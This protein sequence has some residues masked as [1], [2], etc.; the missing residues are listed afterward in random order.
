MTIKRE[1]GEFLGVDEKEFNIATGLIIEYKNSYLFSIQNSEKWQEKNGIINIGIVGIGGGCEEGETIEECL[2][3]ETYEEIG[4][5]VDI[6][7][8]KETLILVDEEC[9]INTE[10]MHFC[11][12]KPYAITLVK[13][14][15]KYRGKPYTIVFSYRCNL[16]YIPKAGDVYGFVLCNK[17]DVSAIEIE[18]MSYDKWKELGAE[19]I[20]EQS[21]PNNSKLIPF[22]TFRSF[23][24][25]QRIHSILEK[26]ILDVK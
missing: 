8:E 7:D 26:D 10:K 6:I 11:K 14:K 3:R 23:L 15:G 5:Q 1:I 17:E 25:L 18:G 21:I 13:N 16:H 19:F 4:E 2:N 22:G 12:S 24:T 20:I 9:S